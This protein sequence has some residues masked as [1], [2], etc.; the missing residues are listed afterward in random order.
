MEELGHLNSYY[1]KM[2]RK[3]TIHCK[4]TKDQWE[5][6]ERGNTQINGGV[7]MES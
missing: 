5:S 4:N 7:R 2:N 1:K 6:L 3:G